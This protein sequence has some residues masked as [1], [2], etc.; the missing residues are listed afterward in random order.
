M[1]KTATPTPRD[2]DPWSAASALMSLHNG[3][4]R[5]TPTNGVI[6]RPSTGDAV[7][8]GARRPTLPT[9]VSDTPATGTQ[10]SNAAP[11]VN[12]FAGGDINHL[13]PHFGYD[14]NLDADDWVTDFHP[15]VRVWRIPLSQSSWTLD[16]DLA[17]CMECASL[18]VRVVAV[19]QLTDMQQW[20]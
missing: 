10:A 12:V 15:Y 1:S 14:S 8:K 2:A 18:G 5:H 17:L 11:I 4:D 13:P 7:L 9:P 6:A 3:N 19:I 16:F 20:A